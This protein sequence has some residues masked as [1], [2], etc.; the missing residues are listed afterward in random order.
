MTES[1][2]ELLALGMIRHPFEPARQ[3]MDAG[4]TWAKVAAIAP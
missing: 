4:L 2:P 1:V 3:K